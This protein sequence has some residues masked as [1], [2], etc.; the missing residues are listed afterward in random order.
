METKETTLLRKAIEAWITKNIDLVIKAQ[1]F[2]KKIDEYG[3]IDS[4]TTLP[5]QILPTDIS[6]SDG[7][8]ICKIFLNLD[9]PIYGY[10]S[11]ELSEDK[12]AITCPSTYLENYFI[13]SFEEC[14]TWLE[15]LDN[16]MNEFL[17][18]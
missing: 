2:A 17:L 12:C 10:F 18:Q 3:F 9:N 6:D 5:F 14:D 13:L 1:S 16:E 11:I 4:G 15:T 8:L 7:D